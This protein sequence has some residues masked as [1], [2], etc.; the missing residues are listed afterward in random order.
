[1]L[2]KY[3]NETTIAVNVLV[4]QTLK[5]PDKKSARSAMA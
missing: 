4:T 1:M 5:L 3:S 2:K